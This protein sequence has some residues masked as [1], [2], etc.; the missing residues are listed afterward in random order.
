MVAGSVCKTV[1][2]IVV[3]WDYF[4]YCEKDKPESQELC[5]VN[6]HCLVSGWTE[7][8]I[9]N[10]SFHLD[11]SRDLLVRTRKVVQLP[12]GEG[13]SCPLLKET[14][15]ATYDEM[16]D[17]CFR[18]VHAGP[19]AVCRMGPYSVSAVFHMG[20]IRYGPY[21]ILVVYGLHPVW[22]VAC[23]I[24]PVWPYPISAVFHRGRIHYGPYPI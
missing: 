22:V 1:T 4:R 23:T 7:W 15:L 24:Y 3:S 18:W 16:K 5:L 10:R 13:T 19:G 14:R 21:P 2:H 9:Q 12:R 11:Q 8:T 6:R 17:M 20:R